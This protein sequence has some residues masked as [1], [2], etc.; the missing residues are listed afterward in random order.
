MRSRGYDVLSLIG[1]IVVLYL[2]WPIIKWLIFLVILAV[3][4]L[5]IAFKFAKHKQK[6]AMN[7]YLN[8]ENLQDFKQSQMHKE[9][10]IDVEYVERERD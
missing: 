6:K 7:E 5:V 8:Q 10:V 1:F 3:V 9:D 2:L 4:G